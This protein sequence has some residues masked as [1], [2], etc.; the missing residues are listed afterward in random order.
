MLSVLWNKTQICKDCNGRVPI[1]RFLDISCSYYPDVLNTAIL[2]HCTQCQLNRYK[3]E[4]L[5][6]LRENGNG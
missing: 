6:L 2:D 5:A 3:K 4:T 1:H